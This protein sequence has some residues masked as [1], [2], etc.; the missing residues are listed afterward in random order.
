M[1]YLLIAILNCLFWISLVGLFHTYILYPAT[2]FFLGR[3]LKNDRERFDEEDEIGEWPMVSV[4]MAMYNESLVIERTVKSI[5]DSDY[6]SEKLELVIGSDNSNDGSNELVEAIAREHS[7]VKLKVFGGRNGKIKIINDLVEAIPENE[8][9]VVLLCD[10]NVTWSPE[11]LRRAV[12]H[13]KDP[14]IGIVATNVLDSSGANKGIS[15]QEETYVNQE[16]RVK[17]AEG[18]LWGRMMGAFGACYALRRTVFE[19]IP[20]HFNVDDFYQTMAGYENGYDGIVDLDA[21]CYEAVSE[22]ISEEF[23]RKKR[24]SKGNFQNLQRY[25]SFLLPWNAGLPTFFAFWSHKGLRYFGPLLIIALLSSA[26]LLAG[27]T[28]GWWFGLVAGGM[29]SSI[30]MA[31]A[32]KVMDTF[33]SS[34]RFRLF[35]FARYFYAM[36]VAMLLGGIEYTRGVK[37][38]VWEPTK[39]LEN[40]QSTVPLSES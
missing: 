38:S 2:M 14:S 8:T 27:L 15:E 37:N 33:G 31:F 10:A 18:V 25:F 5:L 1:S 17:F 3:K 29:F 22:E 26:P 21:I 20:D 19:R 30:L 35:K 6:P 40:G 36:N 9:S 28:H 13:F 4:V 34:F 16:N 39:R 7:N 24:I 32:D 12:R 11:L 23:R